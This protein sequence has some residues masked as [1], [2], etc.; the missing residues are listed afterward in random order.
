MSIQTSIDPRNGEGISPQHCLPIAFVQMRKKSSL[1]V[2][3]IVGIE[4][5][6][7]AR[8]QSRSLRFPYAVIEARIVDIRWLDILEGRLGSQNF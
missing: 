5:C 3:Q 2:K 8:K 1:S 6:N 7:A 4:R